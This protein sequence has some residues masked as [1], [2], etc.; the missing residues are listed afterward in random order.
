VSATVRIS[1]LAA[2]ITAL[3]PGI[4]V[5][6]WVQGCTIGCAGCASVDTWDAAGGTSWDVAVLAD[7][8]VDTAITVG[9]EGLTI[10]GGEPFQQA[11]AVAALIDAVRERWD[12]DV[13]LFTGYAASAARRVSPVLWSRLDMAIAGPYRRDRPSAHPLLGSANQT[14]EALTDRGATLL[15]PI[16]DGATHLQVTESAG[17]LHIVGMPSPGDLPRLRRMLAE[18]GVRLNGVSWGDGE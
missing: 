3:G 16:A 11:D 14:V 15:H 6:V 4:R 7:H 13:L 1:R 5:A 17:A 10:T 12:A 9:A 2:P 8:L 18:R